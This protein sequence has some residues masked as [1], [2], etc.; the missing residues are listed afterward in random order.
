M[1]NET[2]AELEKLN[3][4]LFHLRLELSRKAE[5]KGD[6]ELLKGLMGFVV[7]HHSIDLRTCF[8]H[9]MQNDAR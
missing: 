6:S 8:R 5:V 3:Y 7:E 2:T 4:I 9:Y 1:S